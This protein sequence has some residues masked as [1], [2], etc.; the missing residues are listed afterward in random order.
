MSKLFFN[1]SQESTILKNSFD[2]LAAFCSPEK[3]EDKASSEQIVKVPEKYDLYGNPKEKFAPNKENPKSQRDHRSFAFQLLYALER[4]NFEFSLD[5]LLNIY[6]L[7]YGI[8]LDKAAFAYSLASGVLGQY[9]NLV[10]NIKKFLNANW[11]YDR[12]SC[13]TNL[14]L[15]MAIFEIK[16]LNIPGQIVIDEYVELAKAYAE[17]DAYRILNGVLDNFVKKNK[18]SEVE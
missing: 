18:D 1:V 16:F 9:A 13:T 8:N 12:L 17:H 15:N 7:D 5:E 2:Q 3:M 4:M 11:P 14:L 6:M 10:E